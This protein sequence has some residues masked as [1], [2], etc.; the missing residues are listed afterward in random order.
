M[1]HASTIG[2][3]E[4]SNSRTPA[5]IKHFDSPRS[6]FRLR[7][8]RG[9]ERDVNVMLWRIVWRAVPSSD[10]LLDGLIQLVSL[11]SGRRVQILIEN[12][13]PC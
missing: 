7:K 6:C 10:N 5:G 3:T 4:P 1:D 13:S 12:R 9:D 8:E 11:S 2:F